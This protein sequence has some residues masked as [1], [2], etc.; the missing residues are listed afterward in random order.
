LGR[1]MTSRGRISTGP[2]A[3][4]TITRTAADAAPASTTHSRQV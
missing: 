2:I 4:V 3:V 1:G